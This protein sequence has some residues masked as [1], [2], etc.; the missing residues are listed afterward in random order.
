MKAAAAEGAYAPRSV[1]PLGLADDQVV[2]VVEV[3]GKN[4]LR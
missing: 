3:D 1:A 4:V 2:W